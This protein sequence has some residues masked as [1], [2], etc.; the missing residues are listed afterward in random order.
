MR[1]VQ[2]NI[3]LLAAAIDPVARKY[4]MTETEVRKALSQ[5]RPMMSEE[6]LRSASALAV[7]ASPRTVP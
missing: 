3:I 5:L 7:T 4:H 2:L 1:H 6:I